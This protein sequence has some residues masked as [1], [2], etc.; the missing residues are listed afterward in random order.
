MT[1]PTRSLTSGL[2][3]GTVVCAPEGRHLIAVIRR[4]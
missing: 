3:V 4:R 1:G 2:G